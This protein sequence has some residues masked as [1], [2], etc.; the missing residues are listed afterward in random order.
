MDN[1]IYVS[2]RFH[3]DLLLHKNKLLSLHIMQTNGKRNQKIYYI[4]TFHVTQG[5]HI[6]AE[7]KFPVF[8]LCY[9]FFPCVFSHKLIMVLSNQ[10]FARP[11]ITVFIIYGSTHAKKLVMG[12]M[13]F[14]KSLKNLVMTI[15]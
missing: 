15:W 4:I 7:I 6:P 14:L 11:V 10:G 13:Y 8:S 1:L 3:F 12:S 9:E 2:W 5:G